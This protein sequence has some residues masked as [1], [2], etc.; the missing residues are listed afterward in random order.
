MLAAYLALASVMLGD[1]LA[2]GIHLR[3]VLLSITYSIN[4][5]TT[6]GEQVGVLAHVWSL[7]IEMQFYLLWPLVMV[8]VLRL[9]RTQGVT[10]LVLLYVTM[11]LWRAIGSAGLELSW[12][13]Y[14]RSGMPASGVVFGAVFVK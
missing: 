9:N 1:L 12:N 11:T 6:W 8:L 13:M 3:D 14:A 7:A 4:W 2:P 10:V 5:L